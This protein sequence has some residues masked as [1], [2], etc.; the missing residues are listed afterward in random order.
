[1]SEETNAPAYRGPIAVASAIAFAYAACGIAR[2]ETY[3]N[4]TFDL[5]FYARMAW[6]MV[7]GDLWDPI[8]GAH[9]FGLH[10]SPVLVPIGVIGA[11][12][13]TQVA[14]YLAQGL[15]VALAT[16]PL[17]RLGER[18][19]GQLG[20][21]AGA[22]ALVLHPNLG[23]VIAYEAHPGTLALLPLAWLAYAVLESEPKTLVIASLGVLACRE[24]LALIVLI[25]ACVAAT[26]P[27]M[28]RA[29]LV[30]GGVAALWLGLF[31]A[32]LHPA[33][34][35][36]HGSMEAHFGPWGRSLP[37]IAGAIASEPMRLVRHL[38]ET[39]RLTYLPRVL[40]PLALL[41]LASPRMLLLAAPVLGVALVS[42]FSTTTRIDSHY[43]TPALP[44]LVAG[45]IEGSARVGA[46]I[47]SAPRA[48]PLAMIVAGLLGTV[49]AGLFSLRFPAPAF[50]TPPLPPSALDALVRKVPAG[51][52]VEAPDPLLP[53]F[54]ERAVLHRPSEFP[55]RTEAVILDL[56]HRS[57][58]RH[59]EDLLR[60][61]EEPRARAMFARPDYALVDQ[62]GPYALFLRDGGAASR[63]VDTIRIRA[64]VASQITITDC[65]A[66]VRA[67]R[68]DGALAL[69][70]V[71]R[72]AC[73]S[74]LAIRL[75]AEANPSRVD[76]LFDG[77]VSPAHVRAGDVV[78]S[79]H[80]D[81]A[82]TATVIHVGALRSSGARPDPRDPV[83]VA[84]AIR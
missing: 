46:R 47:R 29:G 73:A 70:F 33:F 25:A 61:T 74:D 23:H 13:G 5:A 28:R 57:R 9:V 67:S 75:G 14:L 58:F 54:A 80:D 22:L 16:V 81:P 69:D 52:S 32:V 35:P 79:L 82:P 49:N 15:A 3:T 65:L 56:G 31:V 38:G 83:A 12:I 62:V 18:R 72:G 51:A 40:A 11:V 76:L 66:L 77:R 43:L 84:I 2:Y 7:R 68:V 4:Q 36:A 59:D 60:T 44:M 17:A 63:R 45:A 48:M 21:Y 64:D 50:M 42:F 10:L 71:A 78:R 8:L 37:E 20:G 55:H 1:V 41:P 53:H 27:A 19:F 34:K 30:A 26:R 24:D 39:K 6:G